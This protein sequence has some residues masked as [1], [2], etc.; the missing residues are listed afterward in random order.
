M[1]VFKI[2]IVVVVTTIC[3]A[4]HFLSGHRER[5]I[6]RLLETG[7]VKKGALV[8]LIYSTGYFRDS[9]HLFRVSQGLINIDESK[10]LGVDDPLDKRLIEDARKFIESKARIIIGWDGAMIYETSGAKILSVVTVVKTKKDGDYIV[11]RVF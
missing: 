7:V 4:I 11:M 1:T 3:L 2:I 5:N 6:Q 9:M 10:I 8:D